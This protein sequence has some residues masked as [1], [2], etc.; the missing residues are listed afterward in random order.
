MGNKEGLIAMLGKEL[1]KQKQ[2]FKDNSYWATKADGSDKYW[3]SKEIFDAADKKI[4]TLEKELARIQTEEEAYDPTIWDT[5]D[6][7]WKK[8]TGDDDVPKD[9]V[10]SGVRG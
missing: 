10:A 2:I 4:K 8:L 9:S 3:A 5:I 7:Y 1:A 6:H